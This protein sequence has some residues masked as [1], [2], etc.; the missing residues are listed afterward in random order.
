[1]ATDENVISNPEE[2]KVADASKASEKL[3]SAETGADTKK[4]SDAKKVEAEQETDTNAASAELEKLQ[5][6]LKTAEEKAATHW[7]ELLRAKADLENTR[8]RLERDVENAHKYAVEKFVQDLLPVIDSL[9]MGIKAANELDADINKVKEGTT[10]TL[11]MF[12]DCANR[13]GVKAIDPIGEPFNPE[14]H[15][16]MSIQ[17]SNDH[18]PD[19][20]IA[21]MQKG[22]LLNGRLVRP[23]MVVVSKKSENSPATAEKQDSDNSKKNT[24][25]SKK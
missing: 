1:M 19:S 10:L 2:K 9:E 6:Q 7:E 20:V 22:Y 18:K 24:Q 4:D 11:K 8:K 13:F 16:A 25:D 17:E 3:K 12:N 21:V 15:Q 23:A 14:F 5:N